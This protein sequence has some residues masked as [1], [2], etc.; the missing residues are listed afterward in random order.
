MTTITI[1]PR[2]KEG[3][4]KWGEEFKSKFVSDVVVYM[5]GKH[6][7]W[8]QLFINEREYSWPPVLWMGLKEHLDYC[9]ELDEAFYE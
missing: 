5:W 4:Q 1:K 6:Q 3:L 7:R 9:V 2:Q 8:Y